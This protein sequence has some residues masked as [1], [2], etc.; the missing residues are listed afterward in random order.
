MRAVAWSPMNTVDLPDGSSMPK[1]GQGTWLLGDDPQTRMQEIETL[2]E[3]VQRGL[4]LID[5]AEMYGNGRSERLV[6]EAIADCRD[7][8]FLVSKVTPGG[9]GAQIIT[10]C[11]QSLSRLGTD[12]L[13]LYLLH[14]AGGTSFEDTIEAFE[15]LVADGTIRR[16]GVSNLDQ[17]QTQRFCSIPGGEHTQV[18][19]LLFNLHQR[20][21]EWD[22]LPW[23]QITGRAVMAYSPFDR[24]DLL[25]HDGLRRFARERDM[26]SGQAALAWLL[27][28]DQVVPIPK[29]SHPDRVRE[30]AA[31][32]DV[33][34]SVQ[35]REELDRLFPRPTAPEPLEI[36]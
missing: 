36:Y 34:L 7:D 24:V 29:A 2:R 28:H 15:Q 20:G 22:L 11:E 35:E 10:A 5:T 3:G 9:N 21:I 31:A 32:L 1:M 30:N 25:K 27:D 14:W 17:P 16:F 12:R 18:N 19:Q 23:M 8:V 26:T 13:D 6:G 33:S 4:T